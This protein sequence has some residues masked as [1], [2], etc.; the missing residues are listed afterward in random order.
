MTT[1]I[2]CSLA[3]RKMCFAERASEHYLIYAGNTA[4]SFNAWARYM[5]MKY[6]AAIKYHRLRD[7]LIQDERISNKAKAT[8]TYERLCREGN[9]I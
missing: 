2:A 9:D 1:L 3:Y 7:K 8:E 4:T 5:N 6:D